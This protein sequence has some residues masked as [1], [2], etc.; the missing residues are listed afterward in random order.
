MKTLMQ[1]YKLVE[2][3]RG[4][5]FTYLASIPFQKL[6]IPIEMAN[7]KSVCYLLNHT[8]ITYLSW[9]NEFALKNPLMMTDETAWQTINDAKTYYT[10]VDDCA[11]N[12]LAAYD[13]KDEMITGYKQSW[14]NSLTFSVLQ[15]FT[16]VITHEFHHKGIILNMTRQLGYTPV[17]TDII[18][19]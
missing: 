5:L 4:A 11:Y 17:D 9:L 6:H 16:H 19:T 14:N 12:F 7:N 15:L 13:D 2:S 3:A 1:Q 8:A 18:R 10:E